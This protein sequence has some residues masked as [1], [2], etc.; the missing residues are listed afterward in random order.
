MGDKKI[1]TIIVPS[2]NTA[3]YVNEC[4]PSFTDNEIMKKIDVMF[5]DDGATDNTKDLLKPYLEKYPDCFHFF[6][7]E[8]GG[9]GSVINFS[10]PLIKTKY[11]KVVDGD[12]WIDTQEMIKLLKH[13][14]NCDDDLII[15]GFKRK[16]DC[17]LS[18]VHP[19]K[20]KTTLVVS[21][22]YPADKLYNF[23]LTIHSVTFKTSIF[24]EN[25]ITVR[26]KVFYEDNE[27]CV[28]PLPYIKQ[29]S[30]LMVYPYIYRVGQADQ[31][32]SVTS[33]KK[34]VI[35]SDLVESDLLSF[36]FDIST[37]TKKSIRSAI[38]KRIIE[39]HSFYS[40]CLVSDSLADARQ[41]CK[42]QWKRIK[43]DK[44]LRKEKI[45][46]SVSNRILVYSNFLFLKFF[47]KKWGISFQRI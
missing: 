20:L 23:Y 10:I 12:D 32:V 30:F 7:K 28:F 47:I 15:T 34:H 13:L 42:N 41:R 19:Y 17:E 35:D 9:H 1:L 16:M 5:V 26:E 3:K 45:K 29:F 25:R 31:S 22:S 40:A 24:K 37:K 14:T 2:Y 43:K 21:K 8:N 36:Y 39:S 33:Q 44:Y 38:A 11:F 27:Y 4:V 6:H 18:L 46:H